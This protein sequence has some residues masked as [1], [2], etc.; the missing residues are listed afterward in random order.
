MAGHTRRAVLLSAATATLGGC[1]LLHREPVPIVDETPVLRSVLDSAVNQSAGLQTALDSGAPATATLEMVRDDHLAHVAELS[2]ILGLDPE[3]VD[4]T[5]T[6]GEDTLQALL[7][8]ET[9][10]YEQAVT[11]CIDAPPQYAVLLGEI[12]ACRA[13][14]VDVLEVV[15]GQ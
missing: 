1:A 3:S 6:D 13:S 9:E 4:T 11:A 8:S 14:H 2:R 7:N 12:A 10:A 5:T 15:G